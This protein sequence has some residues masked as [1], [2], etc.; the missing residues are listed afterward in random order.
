MKM[1]WKFILVSF[2]I[3]LLAGGSAG[4]FYSHKLAREWLK[5]GPDMFLGHL[6][7]K[8]HLDEQQKAKIRPLLVADRDKL[9]AYQAELRKAARV[10]I[11]T[12]LNPDQQGIFDAMVAK[13]DAERRVREEK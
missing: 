6:D 7:R 5:R 13:H 9:M 11:R 2:L 4:L 3:G 10:Q 8:L 1:P 12:L